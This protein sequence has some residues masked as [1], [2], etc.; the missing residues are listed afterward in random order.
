MLVDLSN[1]K[2]N[3]TISDIE[4][5]DTVQYL[6]LRACNIDDMNKIH[7]PSYCETI[8]FSKN[9]IKEISRKYLRNTLK[10]IEMNHCKLKYI[11]I[12]FPARVESLSFVANQICYFNFI[13]LQTVY[14]LSKLDLSHNQL[15][16]TTIGLFNAKNVIINFNPCF[17]ILGT[18]ISNCE[19][20]I[21]IGTKINSLNYINIDFDENKNA[22]LYNNN[23]KNLKFDKNL[24]SDTLEGNLIKEIDDY[25]NENNIVI[26]EKYIKR[27][28]TDISIFYKNDYNEMY[29]IDE[30]RKL[31]M[32]AIDN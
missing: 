10:T 13:N 25:I 7:I 24:S 30:Y 27:I 2:L 16:V 23:I 4:W 20:L 3:D 26:P 28:K 31:L 14:D 6:I 29:N 19:E 18:E 15:L 17:A 22:K 12:D 1:N 21:L 5:P 9:P 32:T 11:D 8:D